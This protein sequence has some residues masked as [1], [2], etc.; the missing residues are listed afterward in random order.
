MA[1]VQLRTY[2]FFMSPG[3]D[4]RKQGLLKAYAA[5]INLIS[6]SIDADMKWNF[7][8][9]A[10]NGFVEMLTIAAMVLMKIINS[11]YAAYVDTE[12]GKR[13]F[14]AV[15]SLLRKSSVE[16]NDLQGRVSKII[17][18]LWGLH[19][20]LNLRREEEPII[21]IKT[22]WGASLL[23][24]SLWMWREE[25]GGQRAAPSALNASIST[26]PTYSRSTS[27]GKIS[28]DSF[29]YR[30]TMVNI[31]T[32]NTDIRHNPTSHDESW[33]VSRNISLDQP[34]EQQNTVGMTLDAPSNLDLITDDLQDTNWIWDI[35][36]PSVMPIDINSYE[37][38][39]VG[40]NLEF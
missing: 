37:M 21:H 40:Q 29:K 15:L 20:T 30:V 2:Y 4:V 23:H 39:D 11:S 16:D 31:C 3:T 13:A 18:Q 27:T 32:G 17:A 7:V 38:L 10:P 1:C 5:S 33:V 34:I 12:G 14:N 36:F 19:R 6:K 28:I 35:G 9:F 22:R 26:P 25:F 8:K 24:D